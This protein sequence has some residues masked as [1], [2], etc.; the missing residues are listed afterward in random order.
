MSCGSMY[1]PELRARGYRMT[2]QRMTILHIL[3]HS[4]KHLSPSEI[5]KRANAEMPGLTEPTVYRTLEFL[6]ENELVHISH[7]ASG[8]LTY[9]IAGEH[10]DHIVCPRCGSETEV[11]H[12]LLENLYR[13]LES[14]TG[15]VRINSHVTFF[16]LCPECQKT[17]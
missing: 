3:H 17:N 4:G 6:A 2:P 13:E 8:H 1:V 7:S 5:Y 9:Q 10:H 11:E 15:Y 12:R 14:A 16:G